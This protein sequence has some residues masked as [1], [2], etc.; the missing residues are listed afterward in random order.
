MKRPVLLL[1]AATMI[2]AVVS[3][4]PAAARS[5]HRLHSFLE[6]VR[7]CKDAGLRGGEGCRSGFFTSDASLDGLPVPRA[8]LAPLSGSA[9]SELGDQSFENCAPGVIGVDSCP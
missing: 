6:N 3:S 9:R 5:A 2:G 4:S 8:F 7:V 1:L